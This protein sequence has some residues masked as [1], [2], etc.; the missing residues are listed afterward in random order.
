MGGVKKEEAKKQTAYNNMQKR[1]EKLKGARDTFERI[2]GRKARPVEGALLYQD[3]T[4]LEK[5]RYKTL[6][7]KNKKKADEGIQKQTL[8]G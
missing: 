3:M 2:T 6:S 1:P 7:A 8:L 5:K 4:R